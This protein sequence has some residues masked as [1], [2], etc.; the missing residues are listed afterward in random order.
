MLFGCTIVFVF[1]S[2]LNSTAFEYFTGVGQ[3]LSSLGSSSFDRQCLSLDNL[4]SFNLDDIVWRIN[5]YVL[6]TVVRPK[7]TLYD[8]RVSTITNM[9]FVIRDDCPN[10][11][12]FPS[13]KDK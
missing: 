9:T 11:V 8:A 7:I 3:R 13:N 12:T 1:P 6:V 5:I 2:P 10:W 4:V